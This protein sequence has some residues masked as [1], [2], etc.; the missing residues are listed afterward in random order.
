MTPTVDKPAVLVHSFYAAGEVLAGGVAAEGLR[1]VWAAAVESG[2]DRPIGRLPADLSVPSSAAYLDRVLVLGARQRESAGG[3]EQVVAFQSQDVVGCSV[4]LAPADADWLEVDRARPVRAAGHPAALGSATLYIG[5]IPDGS[6]APPRSLA[7]RCQPLL[8]DPVDGPWPATGCVYHSGIVVWELPGRHTEPAAVH[9][10]LLAVAPIAAEDTLD[11][12]LWSD[13]EPGLVPLTRYLL[14]AAKLRYEQHVLIRDIGA[15]RRAAADAD[16]RCTD[17]AVALAGDG[18]IESTVLRRAGQSLAGLQADAAGLV[19][20]LSRVRTMTRTVETAQENMGAALPAPQSPPAGGM[21]DN[22][23]RLG[24]WLLGQLRSE[25]MYLAATITRV[26]ELTAVGAAVVGAGTR[27]RQEHLTLLQ[28]SL[29]GCL[30][31]ALAAIQSLQYVP[32]M[33]GSLKGPLV[34]LLAA[35]ALWLPSGVLHWPPGSRRQPGRWSTDLILLATACAA[36]G[37]LATG[38]GWR[39]T[40]NGVAPWPWSFT[41]AAGAAAIAVT[42]VVLAR[43]R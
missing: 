15:L 6:P 16:T 2:M 31:T 37:W 22:D 4:M 36:L 1:G 33:P 5:L 17:L 10:R 3:V 19:T 32:P 14:H 40:G 8:P 26:S 7:R 20:S 27:E 28:T 30:L 38:V 35:V 23:Q 42:A 12:W 13:D 43:R 34:A 41:A 9:R 25:E 29:L 39:V 11:R 18:P 24:R 21:P